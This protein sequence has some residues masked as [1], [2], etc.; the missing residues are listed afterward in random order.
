M[1]LLNSDV[2][3]G[4]TPDAKGSTMSQDVPLAVSLHPVAPPL[5][6]ARQSARASG[7]KARRDSEGDLIAPLSKETWNERKSRETLCVEKKGPF[8]CMRAE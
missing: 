4:L 1:D 8:Y 3:F 6:L 5:P 2:W 7:F